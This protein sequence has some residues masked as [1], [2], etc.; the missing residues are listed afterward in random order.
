MLFLQFH[1]SVARVTVFSESNDLDPTSKIRYG[2]R[3][4]EVFK[5]INSTLSLRLPREIATAM[6]SATCG[7]K[8]ELGE[9]YLIAGMR[10]N[11]FLQVGLCSSLNRK[12]SA[13]DGNLI[14]NL[15]TGFHQSTDSNVNPTIPIP[16][17]FALPENNSP[18]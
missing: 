2:I 9:T 7:V 5:P 16:D 11:G 3:Y 10:E 6:D 4:D 8:L 1:S 17:E 18:I 12:W 15:R 13:V 14:S